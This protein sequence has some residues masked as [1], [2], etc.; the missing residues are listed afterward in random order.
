MRE[1]FLEDQPVESLRPGVFRRTALVETSIISL[2]F[3]LGRVWI[4]EYLGMTHYTTSKAVFRE[5]EECTKTRPIS[6][7]WSGG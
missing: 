5:G 1:A 3:E 2:V 7:R 6:T 4:L